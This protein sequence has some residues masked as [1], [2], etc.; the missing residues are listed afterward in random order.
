MTL[1]QY[2]EKFKMDRESI[3]STLD[4]LGKDY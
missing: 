1:N 4:K 3:E 2:I